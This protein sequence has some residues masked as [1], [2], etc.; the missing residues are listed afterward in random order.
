MSGPL[1][2]ITH[3][4]RELAFSNTT[5][6]ACSK[7][8]IRSTHIQRTYQKLYKR[9]RGGAGARGS[10]KHS[11]L[12]KLQD[13][14]HS[15][16]PSLSMIVTVALLLP[17]S[18]KVWLAW[19]SRLTLNNSSPSTRLSLKT[20]MEM[21]EVETLGENDRVLSPP[22]KSSAVKECCMIATQ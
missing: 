13:T 2:M 17:S 7:L 6:A 4:S 9:I 5:Y 1:T 18:A 22:S 10:E 16:P 19:R 8:T 20:P 21:Q 3:T 11:H 12:S 14:I 15:I